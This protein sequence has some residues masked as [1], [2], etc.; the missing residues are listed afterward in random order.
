MSDD[1]SDL[2]VDV[3]GE[4]GTTEEQEEEPS[5]DP[6]DEDVESVE[7]VVESAREDGLGDAV[8]GAEVDGG[9]GGSGSTAD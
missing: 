8:D 1:L 3:T 7:T 2:F 6:I 9:S 5:R 4:E